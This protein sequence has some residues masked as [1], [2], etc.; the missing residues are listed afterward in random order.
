[1]MDNNWQTGSAK[2]LS[3]FAQKEQSEFI[4][5]LIN[6]QLENTKNILRIRYPLSNDSCLLCRFICLTLTHGTDLTDLRTFDI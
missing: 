4:K 5:L 3:L 2:N 6:K 1:M